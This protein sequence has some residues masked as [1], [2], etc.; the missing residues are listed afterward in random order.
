MAHLKRK[1]G[2]FWHAVFKRFAAPVIDHD[3]CIIAYMC[4][5]GISKVS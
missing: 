2:N 4:G 3:N 5:A 1:K